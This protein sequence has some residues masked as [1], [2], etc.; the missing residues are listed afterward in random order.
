MTTKRVLV[1]GGT[2]FIGS[3]LVK[4]LVA[5][6]YAVRVLDDDSRGRTGRLADVADAIEMVAADIRD[7]AAVRKATAGMD[8]VYHLAFVNG[9]RFFYE[10]PALVLDVG[11]RGALSTLAAVLA[12]GTPRYILASSSEVYQT[13]QHVPTDETEGM[14]IPDPKNPRYSYAGGKLISELLTL[15]YL[16]GTATEGVIFRPHNVYGPDMGFEHVIPDLVRKICAATSGLSRSQG[17]IAIQGSGAETRA[18]CYVDTA[19]DQ[20]ILA[21]ERGAPG[22]IYH[23]GRS[24]ELSILELAKALGR[25]LGVEII[26]RPGPAPAG[27]TPRRCPDVSRI[28]ALGPAADV[29]L[30]EGLARTAAWYVDY[31]SRNA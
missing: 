3:A 26:V 27:G 25:A 7:E 10:K 5:R 13:P 12:E 11:V 15:N 20:I 21:G 23:V 17:E 16:R 4:G 24:E 8:A 1:T 22:E 19:V 28:A 18:F 14:R 29:S 30:E 31:Y 9:T 2:G 6:G